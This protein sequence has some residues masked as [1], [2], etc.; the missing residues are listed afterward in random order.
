MR[1]VKSLSDLIGSNLEPGKILEEICKSNKE[2]SIKNNDH[3]IL[4]T[5]VNKI[6]LNIL[7][8]IFF[9]NN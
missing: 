2:N 1:L 3:V 6:L 5:N 9:S 4:F 8:R 7:F